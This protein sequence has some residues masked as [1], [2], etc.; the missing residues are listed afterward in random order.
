MYI[1]IM[2][3]TGLELIEAPFNIEQNQLKQVLGKALNLDERNQRAFN[4]LYRAT[5]I[6]TRQSVVEDYYRG[7]SVNFFADEGDR[8]I[9]PSTK[10]RM[11]LY[12]KSILEWLIPSLKKVRDSK[13]KNVQFTHLITVSCTGMYAPGLDYDIQYH[14]NLDPSIFRQSINFMGCYAGISA[15]RMASDIC[16]GMPDSKVLIIDVEMCSLH[17]QN[18]VKH[19]DL[20]SNSLFA[21]GAA[22][23]VVEGAN[24]KNHKLALIDSY[25][26]QTIPESMNDMAWEIGDEGF[27]MKLSSYVPQLLGE[28]LEK[29]AVCFEKHPTTNYAI[30]P[31]GRKILEAVQKAFGISLQQLS[32]SYDTLEKHGNMSS[33]TIFYVLKKMISEGKTGRTFAAAFGPGLTMEA[34][35][36]NILAN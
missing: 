16:K 10:T 23:V 9:F 8:I 7:R 11:D 24:S 2:Y 22:M 21:D 26:T 36:M 14:L 3:I 30:H 6:K 17:F 19:D 18:S 1:N 28:Q 5:G 25:E 15:L 29:F 33:V 20:L 32:H 34:A 27:N 35:N 4:V 12:R 31:G 13:F